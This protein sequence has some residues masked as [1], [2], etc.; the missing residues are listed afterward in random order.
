MKDEQNKVNIVMEND[1]HEETADVVVFDELQGEVYHSDS[2][3]IKH[4]IATLNTVSPA[5]DTSAIF[6]KC[7]GM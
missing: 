6:L 1:L 5:P 2:L 4:N 3:Q 7:A